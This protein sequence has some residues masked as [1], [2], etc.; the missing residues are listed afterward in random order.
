M[1]THFHYRVQEFIQLESTLIYEILS[2]NHQYI[3]LGFILIL[4]LHLSLDI[5]KA[6]FFLPVCELDAV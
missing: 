4:Y 1:E 3:Y 2:P 5:P 6:L